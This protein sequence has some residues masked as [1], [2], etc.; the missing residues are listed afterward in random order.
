MPVPLSS[1]VWVEDLR[2]VRQVVF[3]VN[4]DTKEL[5]AAAYHQ[6]RCTEQNS[7]EQVWE[8][9][10]TVEATQQEL[11]AVHPQAGEVLAALTALFH[12][13]VV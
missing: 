6:I 12:S 3:T 7:G 13:K 10:P 9:G 5:S 1:K 11:L 8:G 4:P 2:E